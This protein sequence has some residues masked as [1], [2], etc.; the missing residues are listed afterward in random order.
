MRLE[1]NNYEFYLIASLQ[2]VP[3]NHYPEQHISIAMLSNYFAARH[4]AAIY[5]NYLSLKKLDFSNLQLSMTH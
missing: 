3:T 5:Y 1:N 4:S 2:A